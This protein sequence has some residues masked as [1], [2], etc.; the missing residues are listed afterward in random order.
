MEGEEGG[1]WEGGF[2]DRIGFVGGEM[3]MDM[4]IWNCRYET[5]QWH[6]FKATASDESRHL[7]FTVSH[8]LS[9]PV[10]QHHTPIYSNSQDNELH[11]LHLSLHKS[12]LSQPVVVRA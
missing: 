12:P 3:D 1:E 7:E 9:L 2:Y 6:L 5:I 8:S 11:D 10:L 4:D